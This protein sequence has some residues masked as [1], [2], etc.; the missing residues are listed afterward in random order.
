LPKT[1]I[2][3]RS[4]FNSSNV[5]I[6]KKSPNF[7][8]NFDI[9][10]PWKGL[11]TGL[12]ILK[13]RILLKNWLSKS[14]KWPSRNRGQLILKFVIILL[15]VPII[16]VWLGPFAWYVK[17]IVSFGDFFLDFIVVGYVSKISVPEALAI[18]YFKSFVEPVGKALEADGQIMCKDPAGKQP[19]DMKK[20]NARLEIVL[21]KDLS[22]KDANSKNGL[23]KFKE[24][25]DAKCPGTIY[26]TKDTSD[27][28]RGYGIHFDQ[29]NDHGTQRIVVFDVPGTLTPL[30]SIL[31]DEA[32]TLQKKERDKRAQ[33]AEQALKEFSEELE[34]KVEQAGMKR[35]SFCKRCL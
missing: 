4:K 24:I 1:K 23:L 26:L 29:K 19:I 7:S 30:R 13:M 27:G 31:Y 14:L 2:R 10:D 32:C 22:V 11:I 3:N 17:L 18:G 5:L 28:K 33:R 34:W 8:L 15:P 35:V 12:I 9:T 21:P 6:P 20:V 25:V 16:G